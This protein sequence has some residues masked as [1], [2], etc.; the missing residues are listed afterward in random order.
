MDRL[1]EIDLN[2]YNYY[3]EQVR[4]DVLDNKVPDIVYEKHKHELIGLGV[5]DMYR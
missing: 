1:R 3:F 4:R 5:S 2:A